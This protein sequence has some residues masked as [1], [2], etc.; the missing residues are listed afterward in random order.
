MSEKAKKPKKVYKVSSAP[1]VK[2][3]PPSLIDELVESLSIQLANNQELI[4]HLSIR[5]GHPRAAQPEE[6]RRL[7]EFLNIPEVL[8]WSARVYADSTT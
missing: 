4:A 6:G 2:E 8:E 3:S 7:E 1:S 5:L